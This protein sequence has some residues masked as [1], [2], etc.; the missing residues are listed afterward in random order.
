MKQIDYLQRQLEVA[1]I[2][3]RCEQYFQYFV[4]TKS[5]LAWPDPKKPAQARATT[6]QKQKAVTLDL[7]PHW[8][9][10]DKGRQLLLR[11]KIW[12]QRSVKIQKRIN[13]YKA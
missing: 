7:L 10:S 5:N 11:V 8:S 12:M 9:K 13:S 6:P 3:M 2:C 1:F 4:K